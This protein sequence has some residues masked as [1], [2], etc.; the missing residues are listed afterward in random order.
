MID[1]NDLMFRNLRHFFGGDPTF[2]MKRID[3]VCSRMVGFGD[4]DYVREYLD[5]S[6]ERSLFIHGVD[7]R[8]NTALLL[9]SCETYPAIVRLLLERDVDP[10]FQTKEGRTPLMEAALWGRYENVEHLLIHGANKHLKDNHS[11]KAI[12]FAKRRRAL[13]AVGRKAP[14]LQRGDLHGESSQ[15]ND[16]LRTQR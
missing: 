14:C 16:C 13:L 4:V 12:D 6:L 2:E 7:N 8:G 11:L 1:D 15:K 10:N 5:S 3:H 9:A